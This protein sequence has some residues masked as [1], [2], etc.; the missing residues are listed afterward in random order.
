MYL[1]IWNLSASVAPTNNFG[2]VSLS[3]RPSVSAKIASG[4]VHGIFENSS[5]A[6][7]SDGDGV[8]IVVVD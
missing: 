8:A 6:R 5:L 3:T 1:T 7:S 4:G 2:V